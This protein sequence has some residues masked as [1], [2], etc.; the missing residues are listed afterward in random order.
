MVVFPVIVAEMAYVP[1]NLN[2]LGASNEN[3]PSVPAFKTT[4]LAETANNVNLR[5]L[6]LYSFIKER[7]MSIYGT[8]SPSAELHR[9][10]AL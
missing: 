10:V 6:L 1:A 8:C 3:P 7:N 5:L 2:S 4:L 9:C